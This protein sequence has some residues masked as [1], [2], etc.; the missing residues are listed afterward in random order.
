V[1]L[2]IIAKKLGACGLRVTVGG[3]IVGV[4]EAKAVAVASGFSNAS[5]DGV[6]DDCEVER[7]AAREKTTIT[8]RD[9]LI[10]MPLQIS[11]ATSI[12]HPLFRK[13][14]GYHFPLIA[15]SYFLMR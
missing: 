4:C 3:E 9:L 2:K 11:L 6:G 1:I 5:I 8:R 12:V 14:R 13:L 7:Q 10:I 15:D